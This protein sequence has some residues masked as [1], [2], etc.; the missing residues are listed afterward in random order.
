L[1]LLGLPLNLFT[2]FG[3]V[4]VL[5]A[6]IDYPLILAESQEQHPATQIAVPYTAATTLLS[7]GLLALSS[8]PALANFGLVVVTGITV[9]FLLA[10]V[11]LPPQ[12]GATS[13]P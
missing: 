12:S 1:R 8:T 4:L 10:P 3:I 5:G 6:G 9:S 7:F 13:H 2:L 11:A